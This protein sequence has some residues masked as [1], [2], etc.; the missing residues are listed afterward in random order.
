MRAGWPGRP[1]LYSGIG[2]DDQ[3]YSWERL[4]AVGSMCFYL[5]N[6]P[7]IIY[8]L[9]S[10]LVLELFAKLTNFGSSVFA[11]GYAVTGRADTTTELSQIH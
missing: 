7:C 4:K 8:F 9:V 5:A 10:V 2:R 11:F 6:S 1:T 3:H